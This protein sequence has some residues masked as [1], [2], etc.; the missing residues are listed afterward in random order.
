V[1]PGPAAR[2]RPRGPVGEDGLHGE[3]ILGG[4]EDAEAAA[5]AGTGE[6]IE[7]EQY[8]ALVGEAR[9]GPVADDFLREVWVNE[10]G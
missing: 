9:E 4:G 6:D 10:R 3:G 2:P 1:G 7:I 5:T 8:D